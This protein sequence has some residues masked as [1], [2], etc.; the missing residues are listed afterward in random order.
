MPW[1]STL[2]LNPPWSRIF[3]EENVTL[4]CD[5]TNGTV[6]GSTKWLR[7]NT[8]LNWTARRL[9]IVNAAA[10]DSGE[11]RCQTENHIPSH[12]VRLEVFSGKSPG[13]GGSGAAGRGHGE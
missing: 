6:T 8:V 7:D 10:R 2:S 12:P 4:T 9:D 11:Y 13:C 5:G 3:R 1:K